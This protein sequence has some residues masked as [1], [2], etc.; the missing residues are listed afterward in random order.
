MKVRG[1][2]FSTGTMGNFQPELTLPLFQVLR[3][4]FALRRTRPTQEKP[5]LLDHYSL[6][7]THYS[8]SSL[9]SALPRGCAPISLRIN[10]YTNSHAN[11]F[12][13]RTSKK[14]G[15]GGCG[16]GIP[17]YPEP[18]RACAPTSSARGTNI[19]KHGS[20]IVR[21]EGSNSLLQTTNLTAADAAAHWRDRPCPAVR[22]EPPKEAGPE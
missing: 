21:R 8:L 1:G 20:Q 17:V 22:R 7:T 9:E 10:T 18:R 5:V 4:I 12:R 16:T 13:I 2:E 19:V 15:G 6:S 11:P 14:G 3:A